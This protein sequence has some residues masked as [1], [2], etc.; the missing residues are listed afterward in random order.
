MFFLG[1][2]KKHFVP[3]LVS[4]FLEMTLIPE[5]ELRKATIPIFFDMMQSE[6]YSDRD[7]ILDKKDCGSIKANFSEVFYKAPVIYNCSILG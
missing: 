2:N 3:N 4:P 5:E 7:G 1:Q 6:F